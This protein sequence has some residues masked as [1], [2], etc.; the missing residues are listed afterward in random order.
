MR[1]N[2]AFGD[3]KIEAFAA[4]LEKLFA[5]LA[6]RLTEEQFN[7]KYL[8]AEMKKRIKV[9][10]ENKKELLHCFLSELLFLK[11]KER[12]LPRKKFF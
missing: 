2:F 7:P 8:R 3:I 5:R 1:K 9:D 4:N 6:F 12:F 11:D 10:A